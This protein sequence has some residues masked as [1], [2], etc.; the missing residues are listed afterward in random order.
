[1]NAVRKLWFAVFAIT[2][3]VA[4]CWAVDSDGTQLGQSIADQLKDATQSDGAFI[5]AGLLREDYKGDSLASALL[6]PTD[7]VVVVALRGAQ[8]RQA[9]ERAVSLY[10][11]PF[12]AWLHVSGFEAT[13]SAS[14]DSGKRIL[15]VTVNGDK[16]DDS[17]TYNIAM[18]AQLGRG[19]FGYF[20]VWDKSRIVKTLEKATVESVVKDK[21]AAST[22]SRIVAQP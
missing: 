2:A 14:A 12:S 4:G 15:S 7:E 3:L 5:T 20:K 16:L 21:K 1:M 10:P 6:Y 19:G 9:L 8:I 18:P 22:K 17:R 11:H 13:F